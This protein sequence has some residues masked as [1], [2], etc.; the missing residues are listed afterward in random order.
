MTDLVQKLLTAVKD[1][2]Y[3]WESTG[4]GPDL[5]TVIRQ[6]LADAGGAVAWME[7][8]GRGRLGEPL[9]TT[10]HVGS[11]RP[12][13]MPLAI[14]LYTH[15]APT[16]SGRV[17]ELEAQLAYVTALHRNAAQTLDGVLET[18]RSVER[19]LTESREREGRM[20]EALRNLLQET[21]EPSCYHVHHA[22]RDQHEYI[23]AC[24][25]IQRHIVAVGRAVAAL[26]ANKEKNDE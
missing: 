26:T 22:K 24:P 10:V 17:A 4:D 6:A 8:G 23:E 14:P 7:I 2:D 25:V 16:D 21:H 11:D 13:M 20:R 12:G 19:E 1:W 18:R 15:P 3:A 9:E 5:E